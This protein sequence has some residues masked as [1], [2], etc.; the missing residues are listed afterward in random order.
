M[1]KVVF[2]KPNLDESIQ[3]ADTLLSAFQAGEP[4]AIDRVHRHL[5][6]VK[7][8]ARDDAATFP[9][10]LSEARTV[11]ARENGAQSWGELRLKIKLED[12]DFGDALEQFK[13][14]VYA[15]D[16]EKL[17]ELLSAHPSLKSTIDD[18]HFYFGSPALIIAKEHID[19]VDVL[20]KHG[21]DINAKSQ[22]WAGDFHI[23]EVTSA[24]AA[25]QLIER[26]AEITVH[27]AAEQGWLDWL[28]AAY[29]RD[30]KIIHQ[31]GGDG[32]TPLHYA[33]APAV[34]DW[35]LA[36]GADLEARDLDHAS[37]PLQWQLGAR[38]HEAARELVKRGA[39]VDIFAAVM[40][41]EIELVD[42]ALAAHPHAIRARVNQAGYELAPPADGSHQYVYTFDAAGLSSHQ[43]ALEYGHTE[44]FDRLIER[45]PIDLQ[46]LAYCAQGDRVAAERIAAARPD[47]VA[48]MAD[49]DRR[50]LIHAAWTGKADVVALMA[51]LGFDLHIRDD[52]AMTSLHAAAFHGFADVVRALLDADDSP[53]LDW[54]NGYG[55][56]P[57]TTCLYGREHSWRGDGDFP[58][59]LKLLVAAGSEVKPEW[60]PTGDD[61]I[62]D[63]LREGIERAARDE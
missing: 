2:D 40:L 33:T 54:L 57:L 26:G 13:Q 9:L 59:S 43:V 42:Q 7:Y 41:G 25:Q 16:A 31:R 27:A 1:S 5:P 61:A 4:D 3:A 51:S 38:N 6:Q 15:Q 17:D 58:A 49:G 60:L 11:I 44:I 50:Q 28:D 32:K 48:Q 8:G 56:T 18:P 35:L 37:T 29:Q 24:E 10:T 62:D 21:A 23:L 46:L 36:R 14:M 30:K 63:A 34:M 22:W 20:L 45:S 55:G 47:I 52:D 53:P 39:R 19:V 12:I